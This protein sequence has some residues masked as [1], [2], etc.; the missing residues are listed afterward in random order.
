MTISVRPVNDNGIPG[1]WSYT[2]TNYT[3]SSDPALTVNPTGSAHL[4]IGS[5]YDPQSGAARPLG[6]ATS[7]GNIRDAY[8][9]NTAINPQGIRTTAGIVDL[10]SATSDDLVKA[11]LVG[12]WKA[13]YDP[14][15]VVNNPYDQTSVAISTNAKL[16]YLAPLT[17]HEF[18]GT[19]L[20]INGYA[21]SLA[22]IQTGMPDA[23]GYSPDLTNPTRLTMI[24][25]GG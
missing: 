17:N 2:T 9:F 21:M 24:C 15:G 6:S 20:Y 19:T 10:A 25:S 1:Q 23:P 12:Y 16:A 4:L 3:V 18:E 7:T 22:L 5:A 14:N 11:G 13:E 8:L